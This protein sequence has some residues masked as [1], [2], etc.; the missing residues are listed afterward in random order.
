MMCLC[1]FLYSIKFRAFEL[2]LMSVE[3]DLLIIITQPFA[4]HSRTQCQWIFANSSDFPCEIL[5]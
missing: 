4:T 1:I 5:N 3:C 2:L